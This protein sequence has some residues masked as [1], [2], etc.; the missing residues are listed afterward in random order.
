MA[1]MATTKGFRDLI[2]W[3]RAIDLVPRVYQLIKA[4]PREETYALADQIRRA[5]VSIPANI[6]EG[7]ASGTSPAAPSG[8]VRVTPSPPSPLVGG[9]GVRRE[10]GPSGRKVAPPVRT[11]CRSIRSSK[12]RQR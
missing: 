12:T 10:G 3:Q 7:Q 1:H 6:A 11:K 5:V 9:T 2:I 8:C 4:F